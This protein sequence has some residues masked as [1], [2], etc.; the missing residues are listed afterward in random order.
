MS[1]NV[2]STAADAAL[3]VSDPGTNATGRLVNGSFSLPELL[4][5]RAGTGTHAPLSTTAG[6][7]L[8]L[9]AYRRP[10]EQRRGL[11]RVSPAHRL[12]SGAPHRRLQQDPDVHP[13][14]QH[15]VTETT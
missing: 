10:R 12:Q 11:D 13:L 15:A 6:T 2:I 9:L 14:D 4:Q 3:A 7:L 8:T 1:A 5:A